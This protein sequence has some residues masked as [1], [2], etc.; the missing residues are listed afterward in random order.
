M[1]KHIIVLLILTFGIL[2]LGEQLFAIPAFA[3]KYSMSCS[4]CHNPFPRL[5][6]YGDEFAAN[7]F[8][9]KDKDAPRYTQKT[10]DDTLSLI[11]DFPIA[12][13]LEGH[14]VYNQSNREKVDFGTPYLAKLLTGGSLAKNLSYY[15]YFYMSERGDVV[16][17]EDA[18][19]LFN[20]V[21]GTGISVTVGQFQV[22]DPLFKRELRL[23]FED[24][25]IYRLRPGASSINLTYDRGIILGYDFEKGPGIVVEVLN[26]NGLPEADGF[27]TFDSDKYKNLMARVTQDFG[28]ALRI[29]AFGYLGKEAPNGVVNKVWMAGADATIA[30]GDKFELNA[31]IVARSD[32]NP[33]FRGVASEVDTLGGFAEMI[34]MPHG[35]GSPW[36]L[37]GLVNWIDSEQDALDYQSAGGHIG[38]MLRRNIRMVA[39]ATY[40]FK[41]PF[42]KHLRAGIGFISAF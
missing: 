31:Q 13:R 12:L 18:F 14:M 17:I 36:Y 38:I 24:Y 10:G 20:D 27:R 9:L 19:L 34:F 16:G 4:T 40:I 39:E 11:R 23:T 21:F 25:E 30:F 3:R 37:V 29:G 28:D 33:F 5:K 1:K 22:S 26:G 15:L 42:G 8:V 7:G 2:V 6:A 32:D 35:D 41:G